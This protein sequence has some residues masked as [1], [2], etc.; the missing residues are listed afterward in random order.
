MQFLISPDQ[1]K[2]N[3]KSYSKNGPKGSHRSKEKLMTKLILK[4]NRKAHID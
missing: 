3:D 4:M 2:T 1:Q